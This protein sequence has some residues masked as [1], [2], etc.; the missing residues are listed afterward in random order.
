MRGRIDRVRILPSA[1]WR[2]LPLRLGVF[3]IVG[4][5]QAHAG[6][7]VHLA[8]R[9]RAFWSSAKRSFT[10]ASSSWIWPSSSVISCLV[11]ANVFS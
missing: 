10:F 9:F 1:L 2:P 5:A 7:V 3:E 6:G 8:R 4:D 11:T